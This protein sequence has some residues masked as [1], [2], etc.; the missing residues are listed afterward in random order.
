MK[1]AYVLPLGRCPDPPE[2]QLER[3]PHNQRLLCTLAERHGIDAHALWESATTAT[4]VRDHVVHHFTPHLVRTV[5]RLRPDVVHVNGLVFPRL[6][7][8]LRLALGRRGRLVV[9]HHGE[10]PGQW[11]SLQAQRV[12]RR[13]V[14]CYLFCGLPGQAEPWRRARVLAA[15]TPV[16]EVLEASSDLVPGSGG[17]VDPA[18]PSGPAP[19]GGPNVIW[20]GRLVP[21]KDPLTALDAFERF[22]VEH[23]LARLWMVGSG[24]GPLRGT[25]QAALGGRAA[26]I[27][28]WPQR[29]LAGWFA[30]A[31]V[32]LS[33]SWH[34]GSG[35]AVIEAIGCGCVP[36]LS[37][38]PSHRAIAGPGAAYFP[39]GD[40][41]AAAGALAQAAARAAQPAARNAQRRYFERHLSWER[42]SDQLAAAYER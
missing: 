18:G 40:A 11:R 27:G 36:A 2:Q 23:P 1:L 37:D 26:L 3:F 33:T 14:D 17:P 20:V 34:E 12:A 31:D 7:L 28:P 19:S 9:Q 39:P 29:E 42:V 6:T 25:V 24:S 41:A 10:G 8:G 38:L 5:A 21:G 32:V 13:A 30:R 22:A 35:Y 16:A 15:S 4:V